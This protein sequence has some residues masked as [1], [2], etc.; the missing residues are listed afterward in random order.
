M[1]QHLK[2]VTQEANLNYSLSDNPN[3][4]ISNNKSSPF[5]E[6]TVSALNELQNIDLT[7]D[8]TT[9]NRIAEKGT[10]PYYQNGE[11]TKL[12]CHVIQNM[13]TDPLNE[14]LTYLNGRHIPTV[15]LLVD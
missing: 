4:D 1:N 3:S 10:E 6:V 14:V 9:G 5:D 15:G 13:H 2:V 8:K 12:I 7:T 11:E